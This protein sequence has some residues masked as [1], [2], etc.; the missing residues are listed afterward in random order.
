MNRLSKVIYYITLLLSF[1]SWKQKTAYIG[2]ISVHSLCL[3][4][5]AL[6]S[7]CLLIAKCR[8]TKEFG[9]YGRIPL[10]LYLKPFLKFRVIINE[11]QNIFE[12]F[13]QMA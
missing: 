13:R 10:V 9:E 1:P 8:R 4:M 2:V 3:L 7:F 12:H 6:F 11:N 5:C